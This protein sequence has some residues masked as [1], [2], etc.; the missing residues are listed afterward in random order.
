M[1]PYTAKER[2]LIEN[3]QRLA[4]KFILHH[5]DIA[6]KYRVI[7]LHLLSLEYRR[8]IAD[9]TLVY[10]QKCGLLNVNTRQTDSNKLIL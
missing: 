5:G 7:T 3:I 8:E 2:V 9:L 1:S 10:K 6:Y 4:T